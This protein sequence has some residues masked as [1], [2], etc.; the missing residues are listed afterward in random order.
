MDFHLAS[1]IL[2]QDLRDFKVKTCFC[3][4]HFIALE[5]QLVLLLKDFNVIWIY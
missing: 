2:L 3:H 1:A 5:C 4:L